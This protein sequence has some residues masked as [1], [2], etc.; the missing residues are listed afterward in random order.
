[1]VAVLN[2]KQHYLQITVSLTNLS[3]RVR[4]SGTLVA[5]ELAPLIEPSKVKLWNS[6][7]E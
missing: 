2:T 4:G 3:E 7:D 5:T 6:S 1:M